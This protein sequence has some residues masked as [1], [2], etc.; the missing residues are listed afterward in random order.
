MADRKK[1]LLVDDDFDLVEMNKLVLEKNGY[2]VI[3]AYSGKEGLKKARTE[4]PQLI[5]LD[6]IMAT[7]S[8]GFDTARELRKGD[9]TKAIPLVMLTSVNETVP[10]RFEPDAVWLPVD[11]FL[12]KPLKPQ[13]LLAQVRKAIG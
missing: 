9:D 2:A 13:Q 3:T 7:K 10:F 11:A 1:V 8:D 6:V 12:E 5:V 4:K